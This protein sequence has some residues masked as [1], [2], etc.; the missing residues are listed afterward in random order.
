MRIYVTP[1]FLFQLHVVLIG[2]PIILALLFAVG[3]A[4]GAFLVLVLQNGW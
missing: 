3:V 1:R 2:I 4:F